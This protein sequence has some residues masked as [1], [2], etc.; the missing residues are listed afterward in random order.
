MTW[1]T[2]YNSPA[3]ETPPDA[4]DKPYGSCMIMNSRSNVHECVKITL[5]EQHRSISIGTA[6]EDWLYQ[7]IIRYI[8]C[9]LCM[10]PST[11][12]LMLMAN[13]SHEMHSIQ[14]VVKPCSSLQSLTAVSLVDLSSEQSYPARM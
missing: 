13:A 5:A 9:V 3:G 14:K 11:S 7:D 4:F 1:I 12:L 10:G 6:H 8:G 2:R